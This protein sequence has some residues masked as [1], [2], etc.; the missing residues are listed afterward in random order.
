MLSNKLLSILLLTTISLLLLS[1]SSVKAWQYG[2]SMQ[3][4]TSQYDSI[5]MPTQ[6]MRWSTSP[7]QAVFFFW[8]SS[9]TTDG[10]FV[11]NGYVYNG[12]DVYLS[13][14]GGKTLIPPHS[15]AMFWTYYKPGIGYQGNGVLPPAGWSASDPIYFS[16]AVYPS[17][18]CI[19]FM[20]TKSSTG[21]AIYV[22]V[23]SVA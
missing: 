6:G 19:T 5:E 20:F 14:S 22:K 15:W 16:I 1:L 11:Q 13:I 9:T 2:T 3:P 4:T 8:M 18:G 12:L 21:V 10:V 17:L 7:N 23:H